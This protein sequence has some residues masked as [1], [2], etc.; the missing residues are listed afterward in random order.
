[1][2]NMVCQLNAV[3]RPVNLVGRHDQVNGGIFHF[4]QRLDG[5]GHFDQHRLA[6]E[7]RQRPAHDARYF[8]HCIYDDNSRD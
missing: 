6:I 1:M 7:Q 8:A 3:H 4:C 2:G 5:S